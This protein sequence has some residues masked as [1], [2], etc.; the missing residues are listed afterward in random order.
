MA[1]P[2]RL[3]SPIMRI[4]KVED[5]SFIKGE[6]DQGEGGGFC[7]VV[8]EGGGGDL[9][10]GNGRL[11]DPGSSWISPSISKGKKSGR[12]EGEGGAG[13]GDEKVDCWVILNKRGVN[14]FTGG[15]I[16]IT[17]GKPRPGIGINTNQ[18]RMQDWDTIVQ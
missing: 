16:C 3:T 12:G 7:S 1:D 13:W 14:H 5:P 10:N 8:G 4:Q 11:L 18:N 15:E 17:K 2:L 6:H 9:Q